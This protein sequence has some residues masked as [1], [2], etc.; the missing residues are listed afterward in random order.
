V[1]AISR[2]QMQ[3]GDDAK[4][5]MIAVAVQQIHGGK[6]FDSQGRALRQNERSMDRVQDQRHRVR[7]LDI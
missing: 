2:M 3:E 4:Q 1:I 5:P 6:V 7:R